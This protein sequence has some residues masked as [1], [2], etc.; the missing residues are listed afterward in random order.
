MEESGP[1]LNAVNSTVIF[2]VAT[3]LA[4]MFIAVLA[5]DFLRQRRKNRRFPRSA[6]MSPEFKFRELFLRFWRSA[7]GP[8][9]SPRQRPK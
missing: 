5:W 9:P 6:V 4:A 8:K 3:G 1:M 2:C 7:R